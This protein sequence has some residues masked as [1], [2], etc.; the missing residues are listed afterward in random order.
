MF[1]S[2][3]PLSTVKPS[4]FGRPRSSTMT[5]HSSAVARYKASMPSC[6]NSGTQPVCSNAERICWPN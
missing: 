6:A 4:N 2:R 3:M 1:S 5:S